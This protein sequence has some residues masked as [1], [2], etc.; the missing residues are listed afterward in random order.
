MIRENH[1]RGL[2][3]L[4]K[5]CLTAGEL[6]KPC[7]VTRRSKEAIGQV[8]LR[9]PSGSRLFPP[10]GLRLVLTAPLTHFASPRGEKCRPDRHS[11]SQQQ[12]SRA[13]DARVW[14]V[15][16][17][18]RPRPMGLVGLLKIVTVDARRRGLASSVRRSVRWSPRV[19][20]SLNGWA[21]RRTHSKTSVCNGSRERRGSRRHR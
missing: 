19:D 5:K 7:F 4:Q 1:G 12:S 15:E 6:E 16:I 14:P 2:G 13:F 20:S 9:A 18:D 3:S 21:G 8:R 11:T 10:P 17:G